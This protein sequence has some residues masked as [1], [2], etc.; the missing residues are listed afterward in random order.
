MKKMI[1]ALG[2]LIV[3]ACATYV[4][5]SKSAS[6]D[7][8][9]AKWLNDHPEVAAIKPVVDSPKNIEESL[10]ALA[11]PVTNSFGIRDDV[12]AIIK[13]QIPDADPKLMFAVIRYAQYQQQDFLSDNPKDIVKWTNK[14]IL[15]IWC[16]GR[17]M[18]MD[19]AYS[20]LIHPV[21]DQ[22]WNTP[23]R[24]ARR[25]WQDHQVN[26]YIFG[27]GFNS[28]EDDKKCDQGDF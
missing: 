24:K 17:L 21:N 26:G 27:T 20:K 12:L 19:E 6:K 10:S 8:E 14:E 25:D 4:K 22:F 2:V 11:G 7:V 16:I 9:V 18:G 15:S 13:K 5:S 28:A 3:I 1:L 23:E